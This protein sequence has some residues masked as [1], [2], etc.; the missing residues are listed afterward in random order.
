MQVYLLRHGETDFN[1][2]KRMSCSDEAQLNET[3]KKQAQAASK[4]LENI[5]YDLVFSSPYMR[6]R[7]TAE[8]ANNGRVPI[9][10]DNR[11]RERAAGVLEGKSLSEIDLDGFY[12]YH[13]NAE[14]EGAENIQDFCERVW[15]FLE[16]MRERYKDKTILLVT[17]NIVIRAIKAYI[18]GIPDG[19]NIRSYG[20]EN[21]AIEEYVL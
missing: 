2:E 15:A 3:G 1:R 7:K 8:V 11:L 13:K 9:I 21:G 4:L 5:P 17:H 20:I 16:E 18:T 19:G 6:A 14:Y 12:N 10:V